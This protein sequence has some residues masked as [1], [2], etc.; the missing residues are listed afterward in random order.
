MNM[1]LEGK[2][3]AGLIRD[4][5]PAR[6]AACAR[7]LGRKPK[8]VGIGWAADYG[9]YVYLKKEI[10]AAQKTGIDAQ[11]IDITENT[12]HA[13]FLRIIKSLSSDKTIDAVLV[14]KPLPEHLNTSEIWENLAAEK[15]IDG[16]S[17]LSIGRLFMCKNWKEVQ[18]MRGFPPAT[19]MAVMRLLEHYKINLSGVETAVIGR[20]ATVGKPLAHMLTCRD[21]TV[22]ICHSRT[23]NLA[24]ALQNSDIVI[25]AVGKARFVTIGMIKKDAIVIDVGTNQDDK[26]VFCGDVDFDGVKTKASQITPVPGGVGPVT[27]ACLLENIIIS[28]ERGPETL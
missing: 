22:K 3:L 8:L 17:V 10:E 13:E 15:D 16:S 27:L 21:A 6:A 12:T 24:D 11:V 5:L 20:S 23:K 14:P 2:T 4:A 26:G 18:A 9:S 25:S 28:V 1:I 7:R 19:A